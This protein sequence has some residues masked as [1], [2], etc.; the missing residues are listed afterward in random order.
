MKKKDPLQAARAALNKQLA[1]M[2]LTEFR[3]AF[4][5]P[6]K[7]VLPVATSKPLWKEILKGL[8]AIQKE[9]KQELLK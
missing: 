3:V 2:K 6:L 5:E 9:I 7:E 4:I 1:T 8:T